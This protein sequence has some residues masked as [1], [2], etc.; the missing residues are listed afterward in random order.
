M[1]S[2][3]S[4]SIG[5]VYFPCYQAL[6]LTLS[7]DPWSHNIVVYYVLCKQWSGRPNL[8]PCTTRRLS[9]FHIPHAAP[10]ACRPWYTT[11]VMYNGD[12][13]VRRAPV[14]QPKHKYYNRLHRGSF[15]VAVLM[16]Y[17]SMS[18]NPASTLLR[19]VSRSG[20]SIRQTHPYS[21]PHSIFFNYHIT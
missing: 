13:A 21:V 3:R 6:M 20:H 7:F 1:K 14:V 12:L 15:I 8:R 2:N 9:V 10:L 4:T 5:K 16:L 11:P 19:V 17:C 18:S